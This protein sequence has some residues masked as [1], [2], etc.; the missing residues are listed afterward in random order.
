MIKYNKQLTIKISDEFNELLECIWRNSKV[1]DVV[2]NVDS[3][4]S[5]L[6]NSVLHVAESQ[7]PYILQHW[8]NCPEVIEYESQNEGFISNF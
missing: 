2:N 6:R 3:K 5:L 4:S 8:K 1:R 7:Y